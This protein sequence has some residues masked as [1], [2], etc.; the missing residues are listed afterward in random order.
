MLMKTL[1]VVESDITY[2]E[3]IHDGKINAAV[4]HSIPVGHYL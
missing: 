4:F 1:L 3:L 2:E